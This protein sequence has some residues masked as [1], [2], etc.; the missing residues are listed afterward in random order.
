MIWTP[1]T[2]MIRLNEFLASKGITGW[3]SYFLIVGVASMTPDGKF[4][5]GSAVSQTGQ[6]EG[7]IVK[8]E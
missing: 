2:G 1:Q 5:V 8:L 7:W 3:E 4:I 6:F